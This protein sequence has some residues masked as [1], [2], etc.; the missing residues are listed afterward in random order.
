MQYL[1]ILGQNKEL[2]IAELLAVYPNIKIIQNLEQA[3]V[4]ESKEKIEIERL[5][6]IPKLAEIL[7]KAEPKKLILDELKKLPKDKKI[8]FGIS[9]YGCRDRALLC[10]DFGKKIKQE[11][12]SL[13]YKA[14]WVVGKEP[15]LSSVIVKTNKLL[16][17]GRDFCIIDG[18]T[19][20][21]IAVQDFSD[22][23]FRDIERPA[24][25]LVSGMTPPKL[26]KILINL[27]IGSSPFVLKGGGQEGDFNINF[28]DPFCGSGTFLMEAALLGFKNIYGSDISEKAVKDSQKNLT[29]LKEKYKLLGLRN[30]KIKKCDV[31]NLNDC[32]KQKFDLIVCEPYLGPPIRGKL[33][34]EEAKKIQ[35]E[36]EKNYYEYLK[37]LSGALEKNGRIVL[38]VPY[39]ITSEKNIYLNIYLKKYGFES[40]S[41][42]IE[43][44]RPNQ[45][46]GRLIYTLNLK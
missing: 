24:R 10:P 37:G 27:G 12:K 8:F 46:I 19:A 2:S 26:A 20:K 25:D 36:L 38:I 1:A 29:W 23:S 41:K 5:G 13:G 7:G 31:K 9:D 45:K 21:T 34:H 11:L 16:R 44:S 39:I 6:G 30:P 18:W 32:W 42:P 15:A 22:Y 17:R 4:F 35:Q 43:Y 40:V 14:R 33:S 28:L 3:L